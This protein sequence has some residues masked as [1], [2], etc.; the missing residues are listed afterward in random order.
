MYGLPTSRG[1]RPA[2]YTRVLIGFLVGLGSGHGAVAAVPDELAGTTWRWV[3]L[4]SPTEDISVSE[5]EHY[6]LTFNATGLI[7]LR[8]DCNHGAGGAVFPGPGLIQVNALAL[9]HKMCPEGT[10]SALF[11]SDVMQAVGW[12]LRDGQLCLE[13]RADAGVLWLGAAGRDNTA[14]SGASNNLSTSAGKGQHR[15]HRQGAGG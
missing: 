1:T 3:H 11:S 8:A 2:G 15:F 10:L 6:T 5:P 4:S 14:S 13:L 12:Y 9:T 7:K